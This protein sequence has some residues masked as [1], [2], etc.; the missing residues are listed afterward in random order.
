MLNVT[1]DVDRVPELCDLPR[2]RAHGDG[3]M[4]GQAKPGRDV[5]EGWDRG[6][7][8][9]S[10]CSSETAPSTEGWTVVTFSRCHVRHNQ[11]ATRPSPDPVTTAGRWSSMVQGPTAPVRP[12]RAESESVTQAPAGGEQS[13]SPRCRGRAR[14]TVELRHW[15]EARHNFACRLP[16]EAEQRR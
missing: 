13:T 16:Q 14:G 5:E 15:L 12:T 11:Q 1:I 6:C 4:L 7:A 8:V 2:Q 3:G 9:Q 10:V